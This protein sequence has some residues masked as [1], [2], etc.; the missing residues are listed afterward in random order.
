[1]RRGDE[2]VKKDGGSPCKLAMSIR[3]N[4]CDHM[5]SRE[6]REA[7]HLSI[8]TAKVTHA[9]CLLRTCDRQDVSA[10]QD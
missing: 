4:P 7:L 3:K 9:T 10:P 8:E 6:P 2:C 5:C 1:L